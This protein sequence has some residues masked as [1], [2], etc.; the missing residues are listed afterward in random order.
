MEFRK[1][2]D[3]LILEEHSQLRK[4]AILLRNR[5]EPLMLA[6]GTEVERI[7]YL[8]IMNEAYNNMV[9][10][11]SEAQAL[12]QAQTHPAK[13]E[14]S[15]EIEKY[16]I[17]AANWTMQCIRNCCM[18]VTCIEKIKAHFDSMVKELA[19]LNGDNKDEIEDLLTFVKMYTH[20]MWEYGNTSR[21][22]IARAQSQAFS[23]GLIMEDITMEELVTR[24]KNRLKYKPDFEDLED[25]QKLEVYETVI[26]DSG[27]ASLPTMYKR[28]FRK[29][30]LGDLMD[31]YGTGVELVQAGVLVY[32]IFTAEHFIEAALRET[33]SL[34]ADYAEYS[35]EMTVKAKVKHLVVKKVSKVTAKLIAS[36]AGFVAG[37]I[38][39]YLF[40]L[41]TGAL[42]NAIFGSGA[43]RVPHEMEELKFHAGEMPDGM[44]IAFEISHLG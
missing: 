7:E 2:N 16:I 6:I 21:S 22:T 24:T 14:V 20:R 42:L 12:A 11:L 31:I 27:R 19:E 18:R 5:E 15:K 40:T 43:S 8:T 32:D 37:A 34:L 3:V 44:S 4:L 17:Y 38:A 41:A 26:K 25:H 28:K 36:A 13:A 33:A 10:L 39:G 9:S 29:P 30:G 23:Q 1:Y 35:V